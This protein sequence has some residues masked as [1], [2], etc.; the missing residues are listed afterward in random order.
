LLWYCQKGFEC[1]EKPNQLDD[2]QEEENHL[3]TCMSGARKLR[4]EK[5]QKE[6]EMD[7]EFF[8]LKRGNKFYLERK[9]HAGVSV[10]MRTCIH[11]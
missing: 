10:P 8:F 9:R 2:V 5:C 4:R 7:L 1:E 11:T 6:Y 3:I